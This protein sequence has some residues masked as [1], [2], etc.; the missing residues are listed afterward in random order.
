MAQ[1]SEASIAIS[2]KVYKEDPSEHR[3]DPSEQRVLTYEQ[4]RAELEEE[5]PLTEK[6]LQKRWDELEQ[7]Q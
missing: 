6:Q 4:L 7:L 1:Q 3:F 2:Q 5:Y